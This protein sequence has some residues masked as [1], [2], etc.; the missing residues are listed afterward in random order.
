MEVGSEK[1]LS[2]RKV[3]EIVSVSDRQIWRLVAGN[4][5]PK[6]VHVGHSARW[7]SSDIEM[8]LGGLKRGQH[9]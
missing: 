7:L 8:Y 1:L 6:P 4:V 3:A 9:D 5:F 2:V